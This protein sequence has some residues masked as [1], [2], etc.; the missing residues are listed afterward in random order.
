MTCLL[1]ALLVVGVGSSTG[2]GDWGSVA[3]VCDILL[4][5]Q[6]TGSLGKDGE[7]ALP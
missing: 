7:G 3:S 2:M 6:L 4:F 1:D 5:A